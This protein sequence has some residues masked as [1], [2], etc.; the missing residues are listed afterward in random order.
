M[1]KGLKLQEDG[2]TELIP[3]AKTTAVVIAESDKRHKENT[4]VVVAVAETEFRGTVL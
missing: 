1:K 4:E 3:L 2:P